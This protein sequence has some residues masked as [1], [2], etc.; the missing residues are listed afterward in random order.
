MIVLIVHDEHISQ[1]FHERMDPSCG[2]N[3]LYLR[4]SG[5]VVCVDCLSMPI[6][7]DMCV[8]EYYMMNDIDITLICIEKIG[9]LFG[10]AK[11]D[12]EE[13]TLL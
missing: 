5:L 8:F 6:K 10:I 3:R 12:F 4:L 2:L 9:I 11:M 13:E 1:P 7:S